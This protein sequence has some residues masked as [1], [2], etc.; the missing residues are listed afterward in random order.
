M[1]VFEMSDSFAPFVG[2]LLH[3]RESEPDGHARAS[4]CIDR[5]SSTNRLGDNQTSDSQTAIM[6]DAVGKELTVE[7]IYKSLSC[8][9]V[10]SSF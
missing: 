7:A 1:L 5:P 10:I 9:S 2:V 6:T 3:L 8:Y 4:E